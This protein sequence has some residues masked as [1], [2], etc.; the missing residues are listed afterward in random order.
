MK[1][2]RTGGKGERKGVEQMGREISAV[3]W[4]TVGTLVVGNYMDILKGETLYRE[5]TNKDV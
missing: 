5:K 2:F 4:R 3:R 1:T